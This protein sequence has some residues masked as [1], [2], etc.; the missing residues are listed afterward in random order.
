MFLATVNDL[1]ADDREVARPGSGAAHRA[2]QPVNESFGRLFGHDRSLAI[3][4]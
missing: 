3:P 1:A 4:T 2:G